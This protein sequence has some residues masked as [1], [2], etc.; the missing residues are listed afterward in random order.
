MNGLVHNFK[1]FS[2]I[3]PH[4]GTATVQTREDMCILGAKNVLLALAGETMLSPVP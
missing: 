1:V 2:V 3:T 4:L